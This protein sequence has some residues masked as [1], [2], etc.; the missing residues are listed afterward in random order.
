MAA[1]HL[2]TDNP[3]ERVVWEAYE[4]LLQGEHGDV[5]TD[6]LLAQL[7][8]TAPKQIADIKQRAE[9]EG[10]ALACSRYDEAREQHKT[11]FAFY[12]AHA[13]AHRLER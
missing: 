11:T 12:N 7:K 3:L 5:T 1:R 2:H 4:D 9:H 6:A 13:D 10:L 8:K